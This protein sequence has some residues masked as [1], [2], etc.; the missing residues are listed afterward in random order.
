[1]AN[2]KKIKV[3]LTIREDLDVGQFLEDLNDWMIEKDFINPIV[4]I[5][6]FPRKYRRKEREMMIDI[7]EKIGYYS[8]VIDMYKENVKTGISGEPYLDSLLIDLYSRVIKELREC[9]SQVQLEEKI[10]K[11]LKLENEFT[12][13]GY[14]DSFHT[15][16]YFMLRG[17]IKVII[18]Q[19]REEF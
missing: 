13:R 10:E 11:F 8:D 3:E 16:E 14:K 9:T 19:L 12:K 6:E 7:K 15:C 2:S 4:S 5:N 18:K 17:T 1:M